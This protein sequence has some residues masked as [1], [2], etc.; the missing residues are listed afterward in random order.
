MLTIYQ[1]LFSKIHDEHPEHLHPSSIL[2]DCLSVCMKLPL[3]KFCL[4]RSWM[5]CQSIAAYPQHICQYFL[6]HQFFLYT[7]IYHLKF[8]V[9]CAA[10]YFLHLSGEW[11]RCSVKNTTR[12][13]RRLKLNS[14]QSRCANLK[15]FLTK[16]TI[17]NR[18]S[19]VKIKFLLGNLAA[20]ENNGLQGL[21]IATNSI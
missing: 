14:R 4:L 11:H 8:L 20:T 7:F 15:M 6:T 3:R 12:G 16:H 13:W 10:I 1:G 9:R 19:C 21:L 5:D 2:W 17:T 18:K